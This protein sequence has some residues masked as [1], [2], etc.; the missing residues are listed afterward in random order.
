M[1]AV[2]KYLKGCSSIVDKRPDFGID[3]WSCLLLALFFIHLNS[4]QPEII[5]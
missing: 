1:R 4:F 3:I 2:F 5:L